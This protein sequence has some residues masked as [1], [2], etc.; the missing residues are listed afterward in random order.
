VNKEVV[1]WTVPELHRLYHTINFPEYQR[2]PNVWS[3]AAKQRLIDS[4]LRHFDIASLYLYQNEDGSVD[5][6][7]GRQRIAAIMSFLGENPED[8]DNAF[9]VKNSNEIYHDDAV[10]FGE[11]EGMSYRDIRIRAEEGDRAAVEFVQK[12]NLYEITIV[13]LSGS[14]RPEEFNLQFTRLNLGTIINSGEKLHAM[15]GEMRDICFERLGQHRFL[16][17]VKIPT[18]RYSKEQVAA[19]IL[20]Q[21]FAL[22]KTGE[23][24]RTR[25]FDLQK[26]FKEEAT[27]D[28]KKRGWVDEMSATCDGLAVAFTDPGVLR[29]RAITVSVAVQAWRRGVVGRGE[30]GDYVV[31]VAQ[32]LCRLNWQAGKGLDV[33]P[34]YRY[35]IDFQRHVT[36]ASVEKPAVEAR[37]RRL[38]LEYE[39]WRI[40]RRIS[41]DDAY[42]AR[43][44]GDPEGES[45]TNAG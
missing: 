8:E 2:E 4:I 44:G 6:I 37:A 31:F 33:D 41:G 11:L 45:R 36:Q 25:H 22:R 3:R 23:Y 26:F 32:F 14:A 15:V 20:A 40:S 24:A 5:C 16:E 35:L 19:Q 39:S 28:A 34:E 42:V 12:F 10:P 1:R 30:I 43:T 9:G 38:D 27:L 29:N 13:Q 7:D 17:G 21:V 18:R